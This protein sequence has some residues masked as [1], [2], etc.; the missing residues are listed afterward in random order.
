MIG[1]APHRLEVEHMHGRAIEGRRRHRVEAIAAGDGRG[2]GGAAL[3]L[4]VGGEDLNRLL[5][6][7]G[8][9]NGDAVEHQPPRGG[10][11]GRAEVGIADGDDLLT[12]L[13]RDRHV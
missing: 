11:G 8:D 10:D 9:G 3:L 13:R 4:E 12:Q 2:L 7:T 6:G 5:L 1:R